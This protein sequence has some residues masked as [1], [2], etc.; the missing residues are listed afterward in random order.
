MKP[1]AP[2]DL[3]FEYLCNPIGIDVQ[4][5][6]FSWVVE[7]VRRG[8]RQLAY[9]LIV[10]SEAA[11]VERGIG[12][13]WDTG[14]V[15]SA[16]TCH[17]VYQGPP[18]ASR[19]RY[20]WRVRHWDER[21]KASQWSAPA[22]FETGLQPH[23]WRASWI[24]KKAG[25]EFQTKLPLLFGKELSAG[26][27]A[28]PVYLRK[29]FRL[30]AQ[31]RQARIYV[32]GLGYYEL[33]LNGKKV[34]DRVL[35][36][37]QTDFHK[38]ALY[39]TYDVTDMLGAENALA[40]ILGNGRHIKAF[41]FGHPRLILQA[42]IWL[43]DGSE[44]VIVS[45]PSWKVGYGPL[46]EDGIYHGERY[47]ARLEMPGWDA[48]GFDDSAWEAAVA[49][50]GPPL[51]AQM[52]P[53][54]RVTGTRSACALWS[55]AAGV[56]VYDFGQ[57]FTG[58]AR[59]RVRGP[60]GTEVRMRYAELVTQE[61]QINTAPNQNAEATDVYVLSGNGVEY[62]EPRFTYHGF[63]Y[64]ELTGFPGVPT[65][66]DVEARV[67]HSDVAPTGEF[68][69]SNELLNQI[70]RNVL[71]GQRSN[72]MSIPTDCPQRDER[73]GWMGDAHLS[74]EEAILNFDMAAFY[75]NFLRNIQLAQQEDGGVPDIVPPYLPLAYPADPAWGSAYNII[76][77]YL[78]HYYGDQRVLE[79]HYEAL[80]RYVEFLRGNADGHIIR[81]MGK[82]GDWCPPGSIFPKKTG[83][84]L[85]STW[86]YYYDVVLLARM[87]EVL[88]KAEE[89]AQY[90]GLAQKVREAFN[91]EF[92]EEDQ[93]RAKRL[94][95]IDKLPNQTSNVLPLFL[96]MVPAEKKA[97]VIEKLVHSIV[98]EHDSHLDTGILGTC[99]VLDVLTDNGHAELAYTLASQDSYPSWGYMVRE[100]ATTLWE[101]WEKLT[102]RGMN[103]QNHIMFGSVDAWF[104][105]AIAG[106]RCAAPGWK[107]VVVKP[108]LFSGLS[109]AA[110]R[111]RTVLGTVEVA[112]ERRDQGVTVSVR[113]PV[114]AEA[115]VHL[116]LLSQH[117]SVLEGGKAVLR[118]GKLSP[119]L[120]EGVAMARIEQD[121]LVL[122]VGSGS[123]RFDCE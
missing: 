53:P 44:V 54:I 59:L 34:G 20:F 76:A 51:A 96:D 93:Y 99:Y 16:Q 122:Q 63:R 29:E 123:Y 11:H 100:G 57:N 42:H 23:E 90:N 36:P 30:P 111:V 81:S 45:D 68:H 87:A 33:R 69:C 19:R 71:W 56:Y 46:M 97:A 41:G 43:E 8:Q 115:E 72:L 89:A 108:H 38:I 18:L 31:V 119:R 114:G 1:I 66:E 21:G 110:G 95:P 26:V 113:I 12:D 85:T 22:Y 104:Y 39:S 91:S 5:P 83:L 4:R 58:W 3:R 24:G 73:H 49:V 14:R 9:Q 94:S 65:L 64:V 6:R 27:H 86:Y 79:T 117:P 48:P 109:F 55:P 102:N 28:R 60:R 77:W 101:R 15:D 78:F 50:D 70:H 10:S 98:T 92:L 121:R 7:P 40:V 17:V 105:R 107:K 52:M 118:K 37:P 106:I 2:L 62:Y 47:D 84:D 88:G 80:K 61:G 35:D 75:T 120:P 67:V 103:S 13:V 82:Y 25:E 32:C 116:P 74:A 112:W